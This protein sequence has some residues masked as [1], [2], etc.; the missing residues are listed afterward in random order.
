M[1]IPVEYDLT[2]A[3]SATHGVREALKWQTRHSRPGSYSWKIDAWS[4]WAAFGSGCVQT[5]AL[6]YVVTRNRIKVHGV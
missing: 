5:Q 3:G 4:T 1:E 2:L 6:R